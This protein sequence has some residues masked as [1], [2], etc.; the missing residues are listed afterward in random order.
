MSCDLFHIEQ[1]C[2]FYICMCSMSTECCNYNIIYVFILGMYN[3]YK[4]RNISQKPM[5]L[6]IDY[7]G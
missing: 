1:M 6:S 2:L 4:R 3:L 7:T 5:I